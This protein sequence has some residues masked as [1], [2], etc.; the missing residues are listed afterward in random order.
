MSTF[1]AIDF[2]TATGA[3]ES[4]CAVGIVTLT[5]GVITDEYYSLIQPPENEY[6]RSNIQIHGITPAMTE[7]LPGF[8]AIYPEVQKRLQG[9]LVIAHNEQFDRNVL[10][11]TMRMYGLDYDELLLPDRWECTCRIYRSLGYKPAN[12]SACCKR[13]GI[14][15]RHHEALSDARACALLYQN[16]LDNHRPVNI[17]F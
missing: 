17:L 1:T 8:H 5:N 9:R 14:E 4:A 10:K 15:L 16:F 12:L 13:Q 2:E 7:S 11:R 6:W 3:M